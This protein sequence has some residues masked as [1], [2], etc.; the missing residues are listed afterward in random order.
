MV[1]HSN[2]ETA[3]W[4]RPDRTVLFLKAKTD[5]SVLF[6]KGWVYA[7][8]GT[9]LTGIR[10]RGEDRT[11][12]G[13]LGIPRPDV[14]KV[15]G[16][17][18]GLFSG[19]T[20]LVLNAR[21]ILPCAI[22]VETAPGQWE[23]VRSLDDSH[24]RG[25]DR[26]PPAE[27]EILGEHHARVIS[28]KARSPRDI[29][30]SAP[31][32]KPIL[33]ISHDFAFA[34]AQ[35]I[36]LRFLR[37][38]RDRSSFRIEILM[39][40][41]RSLAN[42]PLSLEDPVLKGFRELGPVHFI[43]DLTLAP[44]NLELVRSGHYGLIYANTG[45]LG[46]LL[47]AMRPFSAPVI[48]HVYELA[49]WI[50][51]RTGKEVFDRQA[52]NSDRILACSH[53]VADFLKGRMAVPAAKIEVIHA[54]ASIE[55]AQKAAEQHSR[56]EV[57]RELGI[58]QDAF[59]VEACGTF[60]WRKGAELFVPI[61]V[62]LRRK[63]AGRDFRVIWIGDHGEQIIK[64]QF[65]HELDCADLTG[66]V[67][68]VSPK[69]DLPRWMLAADCF[70][71]T[72]REDPFPMVM[73]EAG[74]LGIPVVGFERS[75][76]VVE[77]IADGTGI[78]VPF[79]DIEAFA[80][81]LAFLAKNPAVAEKMGAEAKSRIARQYDH[82]ISYKRAEEIIIALRDSQGVLQKKPEPSCERR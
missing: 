61:C 57:R 59:V 72:S 77:Y 2:I 19:F 35:M 34:G 11:V 30:T 37:W 49:F 62:A 60:D 75:G 42:H 14:K 68:L 46:A 79:L 16:T 38:L 36:L 50:E 44:E 33:F 69:Q 41:P 10:L 71:L 45:T 31:E 55:R 56:A 51:R 40:V 17:R 64:D 8:D 82:E 78:V 22:E 48:S 20:I 52:A 25:K 27:L 6:V 70:A 76:G 66:Q 47:A 32:G 58:P 81:A 53:A 73:L 43:S 5:E 1:F 12:L 67:E 4:L 3:R 63:L 24:I 21:G 80:D 54:C 74:A 29:G 18:E 7:E 28:E 9:P 23:K 65:L 26:N 39:N 15:A 13:Y